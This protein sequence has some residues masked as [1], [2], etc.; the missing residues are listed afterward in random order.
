MLSTQENNTYYNNFKSMNRIIPMIHIIQ[1]VFEYPIKVPVSFT[2]C[3]LSILLLLGSASQMCYLVA[4]HH[5]LYICSKV[6]ML[7]RV[8]LTFS[9]NVK[10]TSSPLEVYTTI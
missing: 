9:A 7:N 8:L 1:F 5:S 3:S 10:V 4:A 2:T 6:L